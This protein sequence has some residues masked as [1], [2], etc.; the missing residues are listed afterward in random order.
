MPGHTWWNGLW[1]PEHFLPGPS[2][3]PGIDNQDG[4]APEDEWPWCFQEVLLAVWLL[5]AKHGQHFPM[6][7]FAWAAIQGQKNLSHMRSSMHS[8]PK[9]P[10]SS[11]HPLRATSFYA[12]RRTNCRRVPSDSLGLAHLYKTPF[13]NTRLF[14]SLLYWPNLG[15]SAFLEWSCSSIPLL[16]SLLLYLRQGLLLVLDA[17]HPESFELP[18]HCLGFPPWHASHNCKPYGANRLFWGSLLYCPHSCS[19]HLQTGAQIVRHAFWPR[20]SR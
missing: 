3:V 18:A 12:V 10:T 4:P 16:V 6:C 17:S 7:S 2:Q 20:Y 19:C 5:K 11:C 13:F 9:W 8:R 1:S 15:E 14:C